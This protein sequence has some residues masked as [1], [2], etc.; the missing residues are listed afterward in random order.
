MVISNTHTYTIFSC[1]ISDPSS[2]FHQNPLIHFS[3][4]LLADIHFIIIIILYRTF[5][6]NFHGYEHASILIKQLRNYT[7][8][9]AL[10][11][12]NTIIASQYN[13]RDDFHLPQ[14]INTCALMPCCFTKACRMGHVHSNLW[15]QC[16][17]CR[18]LNNIKLCNIVFSPPPIS[19]N[20][21]VLSYISYCL[22]YK[23]HIITFHIFRPISIN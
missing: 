4:K 1:V 21:L 5:N 17:E 15:N 12:P 9:Y 18:H 6:N 22:V 3:A 13:L 2:K 19:R 14:A 11:F 20:W 23:N 10:I 8:D 7:S 16:L